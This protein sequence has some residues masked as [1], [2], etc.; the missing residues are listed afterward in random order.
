MTPR[1]HH[2]DTTV[3]A[4]LLLLTLGPPDVVQDSGVK[5]GFKGQLQYITKGLFLHPFG[6][7]VRTKCFGVE[8]GSSFQ[9]QIHVVDGENVGRRHHFKRHD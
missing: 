7:G 5:P 1:R 2:D 9:K 4:P 3:V 6:K 8:A